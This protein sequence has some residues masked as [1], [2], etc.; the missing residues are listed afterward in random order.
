[1]NIAIGGSIAPKGSAVVGQI[2]I[3][4]INNDTTASLINSTVTAGEKISVNA[5]DKAKIQSYIGS[6]SGTGKGFVG[7]GAS[8]GVQDI[9]ANTTAKIE[10]ASIAGTSETAYGNLEVTAQ[11]ESAITSIVGTASGGLA[12]M[13]AAFSVSANDVDTVTNAYIDSD[14]N[15]KAAAISV[16]AKNLA[17][18]TIGVGS[19]AVGKNSVGVATAIALSDN[20]VTAYLT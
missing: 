9:D 8:I 3:N 12:N 17:N 15:I 13:S 14:E 5:N 16:A 4:S 6:G 2:G 18:S 11:E 7:I 10:N 19:V 1:M 20:A